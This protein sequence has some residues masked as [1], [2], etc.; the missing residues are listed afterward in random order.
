MFSPEGVEEVGQNGLFVT[1]TGG[2]APWKSTG[3]E[4]RELLS[5]CRKGLRSRKDEGLNVKRQ[6]GG[7][8][9]CM[10]GVEEEPGE[11]EKEEE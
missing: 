11:V 3:E 6:L 7:T 9:T 8:M 2:R 4:G 1:R 5:A 10:I